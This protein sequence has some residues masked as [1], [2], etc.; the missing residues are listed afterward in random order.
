MALSHI[1]EVR[2]ALELTEEGAVFDPVS[3]RPEE[4]R[5]PTGTEVSALLA[6]DC[7]GVRSALDALARTVQR[8]ESNYGS[9]ERI[10]SYGTITM[11]LARTPILRGYV[12]R[13]INVP[14]VRTSARHVM[15]LIVALPKHR[16]NLERENH[17]HFGI[18][19]HYLDRDEERSDTVLCFKNNMDDPLYAESHAVKDAHFFAR[20]DTWR[21]KKRKAIYQALTPE[22]GRFPA[23]EFRHPSADAKIVWRMNATS[24]ATL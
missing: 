15:Q 7:G 17:S 11:F 13:C 14:I 22:L 18:H 6:V 9:G 2:R 8:I 24:I 12:D 20:P 23:H 4:T 19:Y 3:S 1:E 5:I 10:E 16:L 21:E